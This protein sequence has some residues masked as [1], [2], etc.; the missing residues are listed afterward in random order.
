MS[1]ASKLLAIKAVGLLIS[2]VSSIFIAKILGSEGLGLYAMALFVQSIFLLVAR[3]GLDQVVFKCCS[4]DI[5]DKRI[6]D[7][8]RSSMRMC[9]AIS[10][11]SLLVFLY[12]SLCHGHDN[13][14]A[15]SAA[16]I[17]SVP[18]IVFS[19][20]NSYLFRVA[21]R[22]IY[23]IFQQE[24]LSASIRLLL[25]WVFCRFFDFG[26]SGVCY[27]LMVTPVF[28]VIFDLL[29]MRRVPVLRVF[30]EKIF[31]KIF[32]FS[33]FYDRR[34]V[35]NYG[36]IFSGLCALLIAQLDLFYVNMFLSLREVGVYSIALR[37]A[38]VMSVFAILLDYLAT[39]YLPKLLLNREHVGATHLISR[40]S[41]IM[42]VLGV[43]V[44]MVYLLFGKNI[45]VF[46]GGDFAVGY[47]SLLIL[48]LCVLLRLMFGGTATLFTMSG[49]ENLVVYL[50][51]ISIITFVIFGAFLTKNFHMVGAAFSSLISVIV[52][53]LLVSIMARNLF[54]NWSNPIC[55]IKRKFMC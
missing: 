23:A 50:Q 53:V 27:S 20:F 28:L 51:L 2:L 14:F 45:L 33:L 31:S 41:F 7:Y 39:P 52:Y 9:I 34:F 37:L 8:Y 10:I 15:V 12:A 13:L 49:R 43:L 11:L 1:V 16:S 26:I 35:L 18:A 48:S 40:V 6:F 30:F 38:Q 19:F 47:A 42:G 32:L 29:K 3:L 5:N 21:D 25:V 54:G 36:F 22:K 55:Y 17:V 44:F 4:I 24:V 46:W